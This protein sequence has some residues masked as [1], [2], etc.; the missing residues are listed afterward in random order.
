MTKT[1]AA[2]FRFDVSLQFTSWQMHQRRTPVDFQ[3]VI[4]HFLT[5]RSFEAKGLCFF[6]CCLLTGA[7]LLLE[8]DSTLNKDYV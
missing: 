4:P 8:A 1:A 5:S 7:S 6:Y 2:R 3:E